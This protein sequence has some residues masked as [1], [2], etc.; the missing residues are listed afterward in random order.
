MTEDDTSHGRL[1]RP[2]LVLS[3]GGAFGMVQAAY[4]QAAYE[5][6][7]DP[8]LI[9]GTSVGSLNG[10]WLALHPREPDELL[11]IW[12]GLDRVRVLQLNPLRLAVRLV[13]RP[14]SLCENA[15]VPQL[16]ERFIGGLQFESTKV[17]LAVVATNLS[18]ARKHVFTEGSIGTAVLASTAIPGVFEPVEID[19]DLFVDGGISGGCDLA[20]AYDLGA[21]EILAIELAP[22]LPERPPRTAVGVLRHSLGVLELATTDAMVD[23]LR[24]QLPVRVLRPDLSRH[25]AWRLDVTDDAVQANLTLAREALAGVFDDEGR[26]VPGVRLRGP[27]ATPPVMAPA[28][29][30]RLRRLLPWARPAEGIVSPR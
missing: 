23:C 19:G 29:G 6:G 25:S 18:R 14:V 2:A 20:T 22:P 10:A 21:T 26:V 5:R 15:I 4:I 13:R 9:V 3:G 11:R 12:R 8:A 1:R 17:P 7:F 16:I 30:D 28:M 24:P 27:D